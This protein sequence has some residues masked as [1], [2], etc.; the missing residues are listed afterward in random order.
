MLT[1]TEMSKRWREESFAFAISELSFSV[2]SFVVT[3]TD[4]N[5]V[6]VCHTGTPIKSWQRILSA[7]RPANDD[8]ERLV[9]L[10]STYS[11]EDSESLLVLSLVVQSLSLEYRTLLV[12]LCHH[13][14]H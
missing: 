9:E 6:T 3:S 11:I 4:V 14:Q 1:R 2:T 8:F 5:F 7:W 13:S 12:P 10:V